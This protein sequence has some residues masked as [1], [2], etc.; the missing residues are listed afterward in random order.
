MDK[1]TWKGEIQ[2]V[3]TPEEFN[4][5]AAA[6]NKLNINV[7]PEVTRPHPPSPGKLPMPVAELLGRERIAELAGLA[8]MKAH[9]EFV[10]GIRGGIREPHLHLGDDV[11]F[12]DHATFKT[13]VGEVAQALA[14]RRVDAVGDYVGVMAGLDPLAVTPIQLP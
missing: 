5:L 9:V 14:E 6:L 4:A 8:A 3:G 2:F 10:R 12:L 1:F 13:Y 11:A 7:V